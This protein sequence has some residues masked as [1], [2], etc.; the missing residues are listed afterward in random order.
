MSKGVELIAAERQRQRRINAMHQKPDYTIRRLPP[1][2]VE[3]MLAAQYGDRLQPKRKSFK[4]PA[5]FG[6]DDIHDVRQA[7]KKASL[8][9][10]PPRERAKLLPKHLTPDRLKELAAQGK[11]FEDIMRMYNAAESTLK[12]KLSEWGM[13]GIFRRKVAGQ[14]WQ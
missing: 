9:E 8:R 14:E 13:S 7:V 4:P 5:A 11:T 2:E 12:N 3:A 1:E 6:L 10:C